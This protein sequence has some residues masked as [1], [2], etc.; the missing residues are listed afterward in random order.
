MLHDKRFEKS[1]V[2][3]HGVYHYKLSQVGDKHRSTTTRQRKV[4]GLQE[5]AR[6]HT[7]NQAKPVFLYQFFLKF[8]AAHRTSLTGL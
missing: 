7:K 8:S 4:A 5:T 1:L 2:L 6:K 3:I